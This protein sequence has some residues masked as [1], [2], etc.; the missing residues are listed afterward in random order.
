M[1]QGPYCTHG[2]LAHQ[3]QSTSDHKLST[4]VQPKDLTG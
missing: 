4:H 2:I 3:V 1:D